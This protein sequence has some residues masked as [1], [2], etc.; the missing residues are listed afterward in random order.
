MP[1]RANNARQF[2]PLTKPQLNNVN[3]TRV[4]LVLIQF[5][6]IT[7]TLQVTDS[8]KHCEV[9]KENALRGSWGLIEKA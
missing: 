7:G 8:R 9:G 5:S 3:R 1:I 2:P 6:H 4:D